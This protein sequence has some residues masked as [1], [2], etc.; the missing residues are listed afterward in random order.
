VQVFDYELQQQLVPYMKHMNP[1]PGIFDPSFIAAN[2]ASRADNVISGT[3][4]E[5]METVRQQLRD[6]K[7]QHGLDK[8]IV[9]WTANTERYAE[10]AE[11]VNDTAGAPPPAWFQ[12]D[13]RPPPPPLG[14]VHRSQRAG[15]R[16]RAR[17]AQA[18]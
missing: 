16:Q 13:Q 17:S 4:Q 9:L 15:C 1:L 14:V 6:F 2:Q 11:G 7:A 8:V 10:L 12:D 18:Q 5:Q 3:K